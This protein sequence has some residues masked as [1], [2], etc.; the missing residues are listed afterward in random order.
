MN[1]ALNRDE[2]VEEA[3]LAATKAEMEYRLEWG[4]IDETTSADGTPKQETTTTSATMSDDELSDSEPLG[5]GGGGTTSVQATPTTMA[6]MDRLRSMYSRAAENKKD[7]YG[8][9]EPTKRRSALVVMM[10]GVC[11]CAI[12]LWPAV[13]VGV[14]CCP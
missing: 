8:L 14:F 6:F 7:T 13:V 3:R 1:A 11:R 12:I 9:R 5:S 2:S 10:A 4:L